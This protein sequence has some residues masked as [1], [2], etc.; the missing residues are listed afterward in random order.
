MTSS[1]Q[2]SKQSLAQQGSATVPAY[3]FLGDQ[4]TGVYRSAANE[5]SIATN[6]TQRVV[7][8]SSGNVGIGTSSPSSWSKFAALGVNTTGFAGI[9]AINYNGN[10]G[11]G[12]IQFASDTTYTKAAIGLLRQ[13]A[14]GKGSLVFYNDSNADA[15]NWATGDEKMRID[16]SGNVGVGTSSPVARISSSPNTTTLSAY[17]GLSINSYTGAMYQSRSVTASGT[18]WYHFVGQSGNGSA[19]T[20]NNILIFGNGD[21]QNANNSYGGIS[22]V[23]LKDNIE[24]ATPKLPDLLKVQVRNFNFKNDDA[25]IKQIGVVAQELETV[26]PSLVVADKN[27]I[28]GVKYSVFVPILIKAVQELKTQLDDAKARIAALE[29]A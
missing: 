20:A 18:G 2:N 28:K 23:S 6:A 27:G 16:S 19:I 9:T 24:D 4:D 12:G 25:K 13:D 5:L 22:D 1:A 8:D 29:L 3:S 17:D 10:T 15:A 14:N 26:F 7:V 21:I 11:I